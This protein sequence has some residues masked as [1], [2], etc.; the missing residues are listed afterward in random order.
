MYFLPW[1][2]K[3][4]SKEQSAPFLPLPPVLGEALGAA[5]VLD[6]AKM[7]VL[8]LVPVDGSASA[9]G[10]GVDVDMT[11]SKVEET[12]LGPVPLLDRTGALEGLGAVDGSTITLVTLLDG[13]GTVVGSAAVVVVP[14]VGAAVFPPP[15]WPP[16]HWLYQSL[17][18]VHVH[19]SV[20]VVSPW[21]LMPP[22]C[23]YGWTAASTAVV[24][25]RKVT[26]R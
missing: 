7:M 3:A 17:Y 20:H 10:V 8:A 2:L 26:A 15:F 13:S 16:A 25:E 12:A 4:A 5:A 18:L 21:W 1:A 24:D 19:P 22:H 23:P 9:M 11:V 6:D 14:A